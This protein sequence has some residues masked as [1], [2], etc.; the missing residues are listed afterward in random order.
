M[1]IS[2]EA[3]ATRSMQEILDPLCLVSV[4]INPEM[5]VKAVQVSVLT[6]DSNSV[7]AFTRCKANTPAP[8]PARP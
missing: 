5:R 7:S 8:T 1:A 6:I 3:A 2:D 4:D